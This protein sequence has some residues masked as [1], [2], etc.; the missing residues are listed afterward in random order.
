MEE[1]ITATAIVKP[2][3]ERRMEE[4]IATAEGKIAAAAVKRE[5]K[6][7]AATV[8]TA[9]TVATSVK[10]QEKITAVKTAAEPVAVE[11]SRIYDCV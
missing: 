8:E 5:K 3:K 4:K 2:N 6:I 1:K 9:A 7:T 11:L 10:R